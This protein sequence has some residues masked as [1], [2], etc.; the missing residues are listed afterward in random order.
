MEH[1]SAINI[2]APP[3]KAPGVPPV[4][5]TA[6]AACAELTTLRD[7]VYAFAEENEGLKQQV[8]NLKKRLAASASASAPPAKK[9]RTPSQKKR[10]FEK[11]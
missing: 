8:A 6:A 7:K 3:T 2:N 4:T 1:P 10:L 5:P 9:A 11:W